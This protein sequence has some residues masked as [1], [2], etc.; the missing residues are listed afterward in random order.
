LRVKVRCP[1]CGDTFETEDLNSRGT[2]LD[3]LFNEYLDLFRPRRESKP[4]SGE[5]RLRLQREI[6]NLFRSGAFIY[7]G[8]PYPVSTDEIKAAL[9]EVCNRE[10]IGLVNH[11]YLK[12]VMITMVEKAPPS[13][14]RGLPM[15]RGYP[16]RVGERG[17]LSEDPDPGR[18][19]LRRERD[20]SALMDGP[21]PLG[22]L[23]TIQTQRRE[24]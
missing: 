15:T 22:E 8:R 3:R 11:N 2:E 19:R 9:K 12:K 20:G 16:G 10:P 18:L 17:G 24:K 4:P 5:K 21:T 13:K 6:I 14:T 1:K 7:Y 23:K